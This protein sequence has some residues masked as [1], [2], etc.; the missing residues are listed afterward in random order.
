MEFLIK[1]IETVASAICIEIYFGFPVT[2]D[3][4]AHA[5]FGLLR[6]FIHFLDIAMTG[7]TLYISNP[8]VLRMIKINVIGKVMNFNPLW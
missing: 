7:L 8:C 4:P 3:A 6:D 1:A 2:V 5:Q